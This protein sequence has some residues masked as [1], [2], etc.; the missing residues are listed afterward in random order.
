MPFSLSSIDYFAPFFDQPFHR[1]ALLSFAF[2][3]ICSKMVSM[4]WACC[5]VFP[6]WSSKAAFN[7]SDEAVV[8]IF[9]IA[10]TSCYSA[11]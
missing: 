8:A 9:G 5:L 1:L 10:L 11:L 6:R 4:R 7:S 2:S 3:P